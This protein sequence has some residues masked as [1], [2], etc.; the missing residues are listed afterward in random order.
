MQRNEGIS[1]L[2]LTHELQDKFG[3]EYASMG[4]KEWYHVVRGYVECRSCR[5]NIPD[6][7]VVRWLAAVQTSDN[8]P[9]MA[10]DE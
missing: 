4:V 10:T 3:P 8:S 7:E 1:I 6:D 9:I 5:K 2:K